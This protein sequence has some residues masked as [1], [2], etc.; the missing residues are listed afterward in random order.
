MGSSRAASGHE[1]ATITGL[2][3]KRGN[4]TL[5]V[6]VPVSLPLASRRSFG[7]STFFTLH[8]LAVLRACCSMHVPLCL[9]IDQRP[10]C[11]TLWLS[12]QRY[13]RGSALQRA[14]LFATGMLWIEAGGASSRS[15][16]FGRS[17]T[18]PSVAVR[19]S[20]WS[21]AYTPS[22][23]SG[24]WTLQTG[25]SVTLWIVTGTTLLFKSFGPEAWC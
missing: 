23:T 17:C 1:R 7:F 6:E 5:I 4:E 18:L 11:A 16:A 10:T 24:K 12:L 19:A 22:L 20:R 21:K 3:R 25:G 2:L 8:L 15:V 14:S 13:G 9:A